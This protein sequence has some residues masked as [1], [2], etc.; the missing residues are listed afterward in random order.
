VHFLQDPFNGY[1]SYL[2]TATRLDRR[3]LA[4][5][6]DVRATAQQALPFQE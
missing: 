6:R 3:N 4:F 2:T 5:A 1:R